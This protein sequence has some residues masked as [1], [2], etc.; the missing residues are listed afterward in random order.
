MG[1]QLRV[2]STGVD[3][4]VDA[5][6]DVGQ[7][8]IVLVPDTG[9][10]TG[11]WSDGFCQ[12]LAA[13][14]RFVVRYGPR[15]TGPSTG[16]DD[17][18]PARDL[19]DLVADALAVLGLFDLSVVHLVG[20]A[21]NQVI[22]A[23]AHGHA[24]RVA[25]TTFIRA[26]PGSDEPSGIAVP[27]LVVDVEEAIAA[28]LQHT[29]G[30]WDAQAGR[31]AAQ[32]VASGNPTGW[33]DELYSAARH[34]EVAMPW[35]REAPQW[36]LAQWAE[37]NAVDGAGRSALVVGCGLGADA[38]YVSGLGFRVVAFDVAPSAIDIAR[39]RHPRSAVEY[40]LADLLAPPPAWSRA[41]DLVV[42]IYTV[43]ALPDPPRRDA[44]A[45]VAD[46]VAAGGTLLVI[47]FA[48]GKPDDDRQGPPWPLTR[49]EVD[50]FGAGGLTATRIEQVPDPR[51]G[52]VRRWRAE[53]SRPVRSG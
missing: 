3:L 5:F 20:H 38:E 19:D 24:E 17:G 2:P 39:E 51:D 50:A 21:T 11:H 13:G 14:P 30:G 1:E 33:F 25:T 12:R 45:S 32:F 49:T 18:A 36:M 22:A 41:F 23:L 52:A 42:E 37:N 31:L 47:A 7:S 53:F 4:E 26:A 35:D 16:D 9:D 10:L 43:Q 6:G 15:G 46:M 29:S 44:I 34:D 8:A 27:T 48:R 28:I 40:V